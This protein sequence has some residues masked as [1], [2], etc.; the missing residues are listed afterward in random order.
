[1]RINLNIDT[2]GVVFFAVHAGREFAIS[3]REQRDVIASHRRCTRSHTTQ[4]RPTSANDN[5]DER[6]RTGTDHAVQET[7]LSSVVGFSY[8]HAYANVYVYVYVDVDVDVDV[9]HTV[10]FTVLFREIDTLFSDLPAQFLYNEAGTGIQPA[11]TTC[12]YDGECRDSPSPPPLPPDAPLQPPFPVKT[13]QRKSA[14][15]GSLLLTCS[16]TTS[17]HL[18]L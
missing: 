17:Y 6:H 18:F 3:S 1:M 7:D 13:F 5:L 15:N 10:G 8:V 9:V 4:K 2:C 11:S 14:K 16:H 12:F